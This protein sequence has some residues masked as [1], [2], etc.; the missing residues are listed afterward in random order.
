MAKSFQWA[1]W[2]IHGDHSTSDW[3]QASC[4]WLNYEMKWKLHDSGWNIVAEVELPDD[5]PDVVIFDG[6]L[7]YY[8][9]RVERYVTPTVYICPTSFPHSGGQLLAPDA[10]KTSSWG[11]PPG[12]LSL[13]RIRA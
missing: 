10:Q 4:P 6:Q 13:A 9:E 7:F 8:D 2:A 3:S 1:S 11:L 12:P 5:A